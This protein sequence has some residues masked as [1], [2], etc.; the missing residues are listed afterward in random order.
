MTTRPHA[1][2]DQSA[3]GSR[4]EH[5]P[6]GGPLEHPLLFVGGGNMALAILSGAI[7]ARVILPSR[8]LVIEPDARKHEAL[9]LLGARAC[10][11]PAEGVA[12]LRAS[13]SAASGQ[14]VLC[15]KPQALSRAAGDIQAVFDAARVAV[16]ILAGTPS[17]VVRRALGGGARVVRAMPNLAASIAQGVTAICLGDGAR[18]GDD[19]AARRLFQSVGPIV[20]RLDESLFDAFTALAGSG[21][22]YLFYL[23]QGMIE[24]GARAGLPH[25]LARD[26]TIQTL[27]GAAM[28]LARSDQTP[29]SLRSAVTSKGGTTEAAVGVLDRRG[30]LDAIAAA[31][32]AGAARGKELAAMARG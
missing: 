29:E 15:V 21:P 20:T 5:A 17:T 24:G 30:T 6:P 22:A 14:V 25:G 28:L 4:G 12:W 26:A 3:Q 13:E 18:E 11:D 10:V 31:I 19:D 23:A 1:E 8:V 32:I 9:S 16:S 2:P 27:L 7:A